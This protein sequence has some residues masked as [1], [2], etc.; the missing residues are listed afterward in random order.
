MV[1][2]RSL[3]DEGERDPVHMA[4]PETFYARWIYLSPDGKNLNRVYRLLLDDPRDGRRALGT[5]LSAQAI[6]AVRA[7]GRA[8]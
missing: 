3:D 6:S 5:S 7:D 2:T 4:N 1:S 8:D